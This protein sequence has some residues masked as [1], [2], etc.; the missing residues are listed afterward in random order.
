MT[1][2]ERVLAILSR[3]RPDQ[4]PWIPRLKPWYDAQVL[5]G[6]MPKRFAGMSLREVERAVGCGTPAR[7]GGIFH[8]RYE[9]VEVVVTKKG[10][11]T[12][13]EYRTPV[14]TLTE[15]EYVSPE[16][17][18]AGIHGRHQKYLLQGPEDYKLW[19][20]VTE[21]TYYDPTYEKFLR[22]FKAIRRRECIYGWNGFNDIS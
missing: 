12:F 15:H 20:Y 19:E 6:T 13:T 5:A 9:N 11:D 18:A 1:N 14:G 16:L 17:I 4:V 10:N 21:H 2:R 8:K 3:K 22:L 7:D